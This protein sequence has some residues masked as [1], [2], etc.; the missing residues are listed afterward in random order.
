MAWRDNLLV[1]SFRGV[2]FK[3]EAHQ[4]TL[5]RR[6]EVHQY[7]GRDDPYGEDLG[8]LAGVWNLDGFVIGPDYWSKRDALMDALNKSGPGELVHPYLGKK[9]VVVT[10]ASVIET[11]DEGGMAR[12]RLEFTQTTEPT[13]PKATADTAAAV[14]DKAAAATAAV[15]DSF[16][17]RV[18]GWLKTGTYYV[19]QAAGLLS[20]G[21][22][23]AVLGVA[24]Q[25]LPVGSILGGISSLV[26]AG[27]AIG[28]LIT[29]PA[30]FASGFS[31]LTG[32]FRYLA[33]SFVSYSADRPRAQAQIKAAYVAQALGFAPAIPL[34]PIALATAT[35]A[36]NPQPA[37]IAVQAAI[38]GGQ[39]VGLNN[40]VYLNIPGGASV[41]A[42]QALY[43]ALAADIDAYGRRQAL[44]NE[45][46]ST[47]AM[48]WG[49]FQDAIAVRD[50]L[51]NRLESEAVIADDQVCAALLDL[52][53]A[54]IVDIT[55]RS[56]DLR[57]LDWFT[58]IATRPACVLAYS[59]YGDAT[60]GDDIRDR[61]HIPHPGF[62]PGG[63]A[64]EILAVEQ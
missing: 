2:E 30:S 50:D 46:A 6:V 39:P 40:L 45:A 44:I 28:S 26:S 11:F 13:Y 4:T 38:A 34:R 58:P 7:P 5:G 61:N 14:L 1:A 63:R 60:Q 12:F 23:S 54:V 59:L 37:I 49:S 52:R 42:D 41:N 9:N 33:D 29:N 19:Q 24:R 47:S 57:R 3:F 15:N 16:I 36:E 43:V 27:A 32:Q 21:L 55:A 35:A 53:L 22:V 10:D 64:V 31:G 17:N 25:Y 18:G 56:A 51:A 8:Q 48:T 20:G 62:V